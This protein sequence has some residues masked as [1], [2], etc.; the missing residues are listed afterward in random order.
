MTKLNAAGFGYAGAIVS[1]IIMVLLGIL[2]NAGVYLGAVEQ[3]EKWHM[4][5]SLSPGG[6]IAGTV[7]AA[8]ISFVFCY[9]FALLYNALGGSTA[10]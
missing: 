3:M 9:V 4:F 6:I 5:F 7:E 8:V 1:A 10:G 2:G